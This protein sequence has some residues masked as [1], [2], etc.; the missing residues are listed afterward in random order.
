[1]QLYDYGLSTLEQYGLKAETTARTRGALLC[2]TEKGLLILKEFA[3]SEKKPWEAAGVA[4]YSEG[5]GNLCG[6]FPSESGRKSCEP[7]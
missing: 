1:M 2:H 5:K 7:G 4:S 6:Q 3:G